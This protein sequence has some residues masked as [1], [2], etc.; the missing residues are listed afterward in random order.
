TISRSLL[1]EI[2]ATIYMNWSLYKYRGK[3]SP[4]AMQ[5]AEEYVMG[6]LFARVCRRM[7]DGD[8][9]RLVAIRLSEGQKGSK[10]Y[11]TIALGQGIQHGLE[12]TNWPSLNNVN[13]FDD[14]LR[15]MKSMAFGARTLGQAAEVLYAMASDRECKVILTLAGAVS[16]AKLDSIVAAMI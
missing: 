14:M 7:P 4:E 8:P 16:V 9:I 12:P 3:L 10:I 2:I 5:R 13:D 6:D 1:L 15:A 11:R